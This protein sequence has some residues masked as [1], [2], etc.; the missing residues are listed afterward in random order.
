MRFP[1]P[2]SEYTTPPLHS[3]V[4]AYADK[5]LLWRVDHCTGMIRRR[6][7]VPAARTRHDCVTLRLDGGR[8]EFADVVT[9]EGDPPQQQRG[10]AALVAPL[11]ADV[12]RLSRPSFRV[13]GTFVYR[14]PGIL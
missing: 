6:R 13:P 10:D 4:A 11:Q 1:S 3:Q 9:R 7:P 2:F 8:A 14:V 12:D 5:A